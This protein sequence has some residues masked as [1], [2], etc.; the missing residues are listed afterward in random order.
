MILACA[1]ARALA[2]AASAPLWLGAGAGLLFS[3]YIALQANFQTSTNRDILR[4]RRG[5]RD[6]SAGSDV[7]RGRHRSSGDFPG[8]FG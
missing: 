6:E 5:E 2:A 7:Y 1:L 3:G 8:H 4:A